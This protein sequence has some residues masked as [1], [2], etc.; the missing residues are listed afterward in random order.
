[1]SKRVVNTPEAAPP[2]GPYSHAVVAGDFVYL[3]GATP[4][5]TDGTLVD[6][7]FS[8]QARATL[9]NLA[10]VAKASGSSLADAV[11]VGVYLRDLSDFQEMNKFFAEYFGDEPPARTT[12][13]ADLPGFLI[14]VDAVLYNPAD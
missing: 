4:H 1:M 14:E 7:D 10:T 12:I 6:G 2:G 11:R 8:T 9:D 3:A 13:Q 5:R